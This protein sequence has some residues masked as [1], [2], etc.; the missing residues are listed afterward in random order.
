MMF[1]LYAKI[2]GKKR[3]LPMD[4]NAGTVVINLIHATIFS[5]AE[6]T[7]LKAEIPILEDINPGWTFELRSIS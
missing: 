3:F 6:A 2:P 7:I 5:E 4:Y 1:R